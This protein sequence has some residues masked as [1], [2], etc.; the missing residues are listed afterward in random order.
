MNSANWPYK[1]E[2]M[3]FA[4]FAALM[5]R[6]AVGVACAEAWAHSQQSNKTERAW[7]LRVGLLTGFYKLRSGQIAKRIVYTGMNVS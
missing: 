1:V 5:V 3:T 4:I 6:E 2:L 7:Q